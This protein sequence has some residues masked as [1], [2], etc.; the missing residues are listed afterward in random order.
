MAVETMSAQPLS[1]PY[2]RTLKSGVYVLQNVHSRNIAAV[3]PARRRAPAFNAIQRRHLGLFQDDDDGDSDDEPSYIP[4]VA[5]TNDLDDMKYAE[6]RLLSAATDSV[7]LV[8][9]RISV[10]SPALRQRT[11]SY[12]ERQDRVLCHGLPL[13]DG[14]RR[15]LR[16]TRSSYANVEDQRRWQAQ[17]LRD[18]LD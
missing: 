13:L 14:R 8:S 16:P 1:Q 12:P 7:F 18:F 15:C 2:S 17:H 10:A 3:E 11:M 9:H 6:V 4:V 5:R